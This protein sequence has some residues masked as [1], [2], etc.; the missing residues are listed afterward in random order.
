MPVTNPPKH[1]R[2]VEEVRELVRSGYGAL[3]TFEAP[4]AP[5]LEIAGPNGPG[6]DFLAAPV[7][8]LRLRAQGEGS[9]LA[10]AAVNDNFPAGLNAIAERARPFVGDEF[11]ALLTLLGAIREASGVKRSRVPTVGACVTETGTPDPHAWMSCLSLGDLQ[12]AVL[13]ATI[14]RNAA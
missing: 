6:G 7:P 10:I 11:P 3:V 12:A 1:F 14:I 9:P 13:R 5:W 4:G 8:T 2:V